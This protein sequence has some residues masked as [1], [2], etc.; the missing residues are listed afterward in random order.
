MLVHQNEN[1]KPA[2]L[3]EANEVFN[4]LLNEIRQDICAML[5]PMFKNRFLYL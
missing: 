4:D 5:F 2:H 1:I 3:E